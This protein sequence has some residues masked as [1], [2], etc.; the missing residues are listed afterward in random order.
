MC[1]VLLFFLFYSRFIVLRYVSLN[2][3]WLPHLF[4]DSQKE[5]KRSERKCMRAGKYCN[6][7]NQMEYHE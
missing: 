7:F 4:D 5:K 1:T 2:H 6:T 3:H